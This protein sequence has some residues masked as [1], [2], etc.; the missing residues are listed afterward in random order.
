MLS[1]N[2]L[3]ALCGTKT[4]QEFREE[5]ANE[6]NDK[7]IADLVGVADETYPA[8]KGAKKALREENIRRKAAGEAKNP[9]PKGFCLASAYLP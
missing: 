9:Y 4:V 8:K 1:V 6:L 7:N 3:S 2:F 5:Y